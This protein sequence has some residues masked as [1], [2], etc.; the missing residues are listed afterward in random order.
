MQIQIESEQMVLIA[1]QMILPAAYEHQARLAEAVGSTQAAGVDC[2]D[3]V[4]TLEQ[5]VA[6]VTQFS[7]QLNALAATENH[8]DG[9]PKEH[10]T[11]MRDTVIPR[12]EELRRLG[13]LLEQHVAY[14]LWP[15]PT[16]RELLFIK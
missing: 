8:E 2:D 14:D 10:A 9:D 7:Q 1:R 4:N 11:Y 12:M 3:A 13:D 16:Y 6:L 5:F 15:L